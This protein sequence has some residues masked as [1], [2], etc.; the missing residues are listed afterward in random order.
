M[1]RLDLKLCGFE[2][3]SMKDAQMRCVGV[4]MKGSEDVK[5]KS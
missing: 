2:Y 3:V 4:K 1:M 5:M